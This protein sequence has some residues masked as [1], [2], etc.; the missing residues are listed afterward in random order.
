MV[1]ILYKTILNNRASLSHCGKMIDLKNEYTD[2]ESEGILC[3]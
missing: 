1:L 3:V 2:P